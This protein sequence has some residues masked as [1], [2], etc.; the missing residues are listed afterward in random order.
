M[1]LIA[2]DIGNTNIALGVFVGEQ[3][4]QSQRVAIREPGN[5]GDV[6]A[7]LRKHC[8][9]QP[10]GAATVPVVVSSVNSEGLALVR[11]AVGERL[12]QNILLIG[13][14]V[15][16][17][18]KVAVANTE[19]LGSDRLL[20]AFAAY[21]VIEDAVVVAS[22]GTATTIDLVNSQGI[23]LGGMILPGLALGA[24]SLHEFTD[25]LPEVKIEMPTWLYGTNTVAAIQSGL[26]YG[27]MGALR[28]IVERYALELGRWPE[29]VITGGFGKLIAEK[30]EFVNAM[31]PDLCLNGIYLTYRNY[32][33]ADENEL[34]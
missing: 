9:P 22:F 27:A 13:R 1:D 14:E 33:Q 7:D 23:F 6:L 31:V 20:N 32:R 21:E 4:V 34:S 17:E 18:M 12:N 11:A 3:P 19:T 2:V 5:L 8:G 24:K 10:L 26:Y 30:C 28:E 16:L 29:V 15:P 25:A